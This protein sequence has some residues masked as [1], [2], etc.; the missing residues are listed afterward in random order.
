MRLLHELFGVYKRISAEA[1]RRHDA[2]HRATHRLVIVDDRYDRCVLQLLILEIGTRPR[3]ISG[4]RV[5]LHATKICRSDRPKNHIKVLDQL[6]IPKA[7]PSAS[8]C[9]ISRAG[10]SFGR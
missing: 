10:A 9:A 1:E 3:R 7:R 6:E 4:G 8:V 2:L 5:S